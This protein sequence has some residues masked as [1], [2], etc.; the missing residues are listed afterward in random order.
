MYLFVLPLEILVSV[1][2]VAPLSLSPKYITSQE[3]KH[4]FS[5]KNN[6]NL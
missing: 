2:K 4:T 5:T 6:N 1:R 3:E